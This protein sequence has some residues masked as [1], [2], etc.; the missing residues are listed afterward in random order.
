M[1]TE[2]RDHGRLTDQPAA[3]G[4]RQVL[5]ADAARLSCWAKLLPPA[6]LQ[7][8]QSVLNGETFVAL[9]GR[10]GRTPAAVRRRYLRL[11]ELLNSRPA[12][13]FIDHL[14]R[15]TARERELGRLA[16]M[17][18]QSYRELARQLGLTIHRVRRDLSTL[19]ARL[20]ELGSQW[21]A[22]AAL[23]RPARREVAPAIRP[24]V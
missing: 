9:A 17:A 13:Q 18:G 10:V 16:F 12:R 15:L 5:L 6:D 24:T 4:R 14:I 7:I 11:I 22:G 1:V 20:E 19:K 3:A 8:V 21:S 2:I 23:A